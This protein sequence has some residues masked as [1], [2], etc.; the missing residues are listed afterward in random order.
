MST[1]KVG[2]PFP[3]TDKPNAVAKVRTMILRAEF[4]SLS[5]LD[6]ITRTSTLDRARKVVIGSGGKVGDQSGEVNGMNL[7]EGGET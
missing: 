5:D 7:R 6:G 1:S 3:G 2:R 4:Q